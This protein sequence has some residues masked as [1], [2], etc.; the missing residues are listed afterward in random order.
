[1][2]ERAFELQIFQNAL[3]SICMYPI[4]LYKNSCYDN[5]RQML[6]GDGEAM[7][8]LRALSGAKRYDEVISAL[9]T[10]LKK[11][12]RSYYPPLCE[13]LEPYSEA[14][15][16]FMWETKP[17]N[18]LVFTREIKSNKTLWMM[19]MFYDLIPGEFIEKAFATPYLRRCLIDMNTV[20]VRLD[21]RYSVVI[22]DATRPR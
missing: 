1:M 20:C 15:R 13:I 10:L 3:S 12:P 16:T 2:I 18:S 6:S 22:L 14:L 4:R 5:V 17:S 8:K 9:Q 19:L 7:A 21:A 11:D